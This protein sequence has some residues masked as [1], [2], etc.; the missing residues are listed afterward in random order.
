GL[1]ADLQGKILPFQGHVMDI[2]PTCIDIVKGTYPSR[3]KDNDILPME[4][5]SI[6]PLVNGQSVERGTPIYWEHEG[7]RAMLNGDWKIVS[8]V[9]EPWQ[10]YNLRTDRTETKDLAK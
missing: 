5:V 3:Y 1:S 4:G 8:N 10:L 6:L 2:M 7:N 9:R